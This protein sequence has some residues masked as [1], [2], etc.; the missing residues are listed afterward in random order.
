[1]AHNWDVCSESSPIT[2]V[3]PRGVLVQFGDPGHG[4]QGST[5]SGPERTDHQAEVIT[6]HSPSAV[7]YAVESTPPWARLADPNGDG[8]WS[9]EAVAP[10]R[11]RTV[12]ILSLPR[13]LA[14]KPEG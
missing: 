1:V 14:Y 11:A 10:R 2:C 6:D 4:G 8:K 3:D 7:R 13:P 5:S 9:C 12:L